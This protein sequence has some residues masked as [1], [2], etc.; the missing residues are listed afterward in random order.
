LPPSSSSI[1]RTSAPAPRSA[2]TGSQCD[3]APVLAAGTVTPLVT[4]WPFVRARLVRARSRHVGEHHTVEAARPLR[5]PPQPRHALG[6]VVIA[7]AGESGSAGPMSGS[8]SSM[9]ASSHD[10][11]TGTTTSRRRARSST[12]RSLAVR[13]PKMPDAIAGSDRPYSAQSS[14][15][16]HEAQTFFARSS[17][18]PRDGKNHAG[19]TPGLRQAAS[20][21]CGAPGQPSPGTDTQRGNWRSVGSCWQVDCGGGRYCVA[22]FC[23]QSVGTSHRKVPSTR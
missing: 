5:S 18:V 4:A 7:I 6:S 2:A 11:M 21:K 16:G 8:R 20:G 14:W 22:R 13:P 15:D 10:A 23:G 9:D 1:D 19:S 12:R 17:A 3:S